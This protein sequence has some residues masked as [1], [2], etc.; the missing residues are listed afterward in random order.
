MSVAGG[1][2]ARGPRRRPWAMLAVLLVGALGIALVPAAGFRRGC[3][4][5][6]AAPLLGALLRALLPSVDAG[7]LAVRSRGVDVSV[8]LALAFALAILA[9]AVPT[10]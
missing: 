4:V 3:L 8:L 2:L 10:H 1:G 6:A 7:P 9:V 5:L